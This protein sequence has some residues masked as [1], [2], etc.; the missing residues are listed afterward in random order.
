MSTLLAL[1]LASTSSLSPLLAAV[2]AGYVGPTRPATV[3]IL[4]KGDEQSALIAGLAKRG[5]HDMVVKEG[6][7][8]L[9]RFTNHR[10]MNA[11]RYRLAGAYFELGKTRE[12]LAQYQALDGVNGF[13]QAM[14]VKFRLGQCA[15]ELGENAV[16]VQSLRAVEASNADYLKTPAIYLLA[17]AL[18]RSESFDEAGAAY[19]RVLKRTDDSA[20][21]YARDARYGRTWSAW[22]KKNFDGTI[23][24]AQDF[25]GQHGEDP[26]AGELA[27]LAGEAHLEAGRPADAIQWYGRVT[28]G[29]YAEVAL[30]GAGFAEVTQGNATAA[31]S[32]FGRYLSQFPK[33]RFA[34]E[35]ALQRGVQLV[36]AKA[37]AEAATALRSAPT[38]QD[39][40]ARY[41]LAMAEA[42]QGRHEAAL[43]AAQDGLKKNPDETLGVQLRIAAG[44]ALFELGRSQEAAAFYEQ[45][46][47]SYALHA[48][49]VARLNAGD[50]KEAERLARTLLTGAARQPGT[51]FR[52][53]ALLTRAEAL[54][55]MERYGEAEPLLRTLLDE[56]RQKIAAE[57]AAE[58]GAKVDP[59]LVS[60]ANSRLAWCQWYADNTA[61]AR[62]LFAAASRD[63]NLTE[64]ER[65]EA[66]FMTGRA[67]L[68]GGDSQGAIQAFTAYATATGKEGA[69]ADE[70]LLRLARLTPGAG[71]AAF[72]GRLVAEHPSST[73]A[74]AAL[75]EAAERYI[76][77]GD[78]AQGAAS[79]AM[80]VER[81]PQHELSRNAR[82]GLGWARYQAG[83]YAPA[84][85]PLWDVA[86]DSG[87]SEELRTASLELLVW[88]FAKA[89]NPTDAAVAFQAFASRS[90]DEQRL[91]SAARLVDG[92]LAEAGDLDGRKS[93]WQSLTTKFKGAEGVASARIELGFV[94]LDQGDIQGA[95]QQ[96]IAGRQALPESPDVAELLFFVGEA[97]YEAGDDE[98]AAPLY[99]ASSQ[100]AADEVAERALYKGGFSELRRGQ[101]AN[102]AKAF[103]TL[104]ERFPK[105][106]LAPESMFLAGEACYRE[107][108][109][110]ASAVWLRQMVKDFPSHA[111]RSK[112]L[113]RLGL[114]EGRLENWGA[115]ADALGSLVSRY[116]DFASL[117]E[118]E[119]WRGRALSR[120]GDRR[121]ARQSL[122]RVIESD[123][124]IL[125]A[126]ARI[127]TGRILE[128][129]NDLEGA[130]S[131]YLKV[132][133][134]YGHAEECAEAL[135]RAGE[136][137]ERSGEAERARERY[138]EVL[139]DYPKTKYAVEAKK[140]LAGGV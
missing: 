109:F 104:V 48:A 20:A 98:R 29:E 69:F 22:K 123:E 76:S 62:Q 18:F 117:T 40:Q 99:V 28:K 44:D 87:A 4:D 13:E 33:G 78:S 19:G 70:V 129:E 140:R 27:F 55:R 23:A 83:E 128:D 5:L 68:K 101:N 118:A 100:Y 35:V 43:A 32:R 138:E 54:F 96:A 24:G 82:Y 59:S 73:L 127:E 67:A 58:G 56:A 114:T 15:V 31:A 125:A 126:Q 2:P 136:V 34:A 47:S 8:F 7:D 1:A 111:S 113:F 41:W 80:L 134:L 77:L 90:S 95:A 97:Y 14:E 38:V 61:G 119:L 60:R 65:A 103:G 25:L 17:E 71:G 133:V 110:E 42:G 85:E 91:L 120:R 106:V 6:T 94:A 132:A 131:E 16:A 21:E 9:Q 107:E 11:V 26:Q 63:R 84:T 92:V 52:L 75:S 37:F 116:P 105:G 46:G 45:S 39:A 112:A 86:R 64:A 88:S 3:L 122:G 115:S 121:A 72:Y 49:A 51:E 124:G 89:E 135:V 30:R 108:Q 66:L 36:R 50:A 130:L 102:A 137:L 81:F 74:P 93:L 139:E 12:S 57:G 10:R 53:E 79:Y